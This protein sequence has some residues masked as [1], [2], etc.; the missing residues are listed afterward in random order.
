MISKTSRFGCGHAVD[1]SPKSR[2][3]NKLNPDLLRIV[4]SNLC[5]KDI[6][7]LDVT[8]SDSKELE[9]LWRPALLGM[10]F[11]KSLL[12][13]S[14]YHP[15]DHHHCGAERG[16]CTRWMSLLRWM[17][18]RQ[19]PLPQLLITNFSALPNEDIAVL[20][21]CN[22]EKIE[23][24]FISSDT[25]QAL[26]L[27]IF[28]QQLTFLKRLEVGKMAL[29][30]SLLGLNRLR[31]LIF[32]D[33]FLDG[34]EK[35][36]SSVCTQIYSLSCLE[37]LRLGYASLTPSSLAGLA[38]LTRLHTLQLTAYS[39]IVDDDLE[40]LSSLKKLQS[41]TVDACERC[42]EALTDGGLLHIEDL[43]SLKTLNLSN[44]ILTGQGIDSIARLTK[45]EILSLTYCSIP[46]DCFSRLLSPNQIKSLSLG[47]WEV[48][49]I[50]IAIGDE[51]ISHLHHL[52]RLEVFEL[53]S[54]QVTDIGLSH[55]FELPFIMTI[56]L[57][58]V[59]GITHSG[60]NTLKRRFKD[61]G[62]LVKIL[63][64]ND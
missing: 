60:V 2:P 43:L 61:A 32:L 6:C 35:L 28:L 42:Q 24:V 19:I 56:N 9:T 1:E 10:D 11:G 53:L 7:A 50:E 20:L 4:L 27:P 17:E 59:H 40:F 13:F 18:K 57:E 36:S 22:K 30:P 3:F 29:P 46:V 47:G 26:G 39:D 44:W 45:L 25:N 52:Q 5:D 16:D 8:I 49:G 58:Y 14:Q 31:E 41:L 15:P 64:S 12:A 63:L 51:H 54:T 37:V 34:S 21:N 33:G 23:H 62:R 48:A 55:T 38:Q